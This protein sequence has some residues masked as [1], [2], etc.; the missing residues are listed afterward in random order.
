MRALGLEVIDVDR[1]DLGL[2]NEC[3]E[4]GGVLVTSGAWSGLHPGVVTVRLAEPREA[5][6]ALLYPLEPAVSV[7]A[8]I[9]ANNALLESSVVAYPDLSTKEY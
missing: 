5:A 8:F 2:F 4:S 6:C 1:Y 9:D 7:Q 3:V